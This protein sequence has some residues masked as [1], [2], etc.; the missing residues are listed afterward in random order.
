LRLVDGLLPTFSILLPGRLLLR[1]F[2]VALFLVPFVG[3]SG[4]P[5]R[6]LVGR[7]GRSFLR[8][9]SV[10]PRSLAMLAKL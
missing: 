6:S 2:A 5:L 1:P 10:K 4:L 9:T 3:E 8:F 7:T